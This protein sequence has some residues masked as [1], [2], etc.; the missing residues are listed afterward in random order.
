MKT[1]EKSLSFPNKQQYA[2]VSKSDLNKPWHRDMIKIPFMCD[3]KVHC[4]FHPR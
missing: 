3:S 2:K 4:F 1:M